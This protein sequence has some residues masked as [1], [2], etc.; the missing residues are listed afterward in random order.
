MAGDGALGVHVALLRSINVGKANRISM[1]DLRAVFED[2]GCTDVRTYIQSGN[3]VF[4]AP[5]REVQG[6]A[7]RVEKALAAAHGIEVPVILRT[8]DELRAVTA[9]NPFPRAELAARHVVFLRDAPQGPDPLA[10]LDPA[11]HAPLEMALVGRELHLM[12]PEGMARVKLTN[13]KMD[14]AFGTATTTRN[15]RTVSKVIAML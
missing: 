11:S 8:G 13:A 4:G 14:R 9:A 12:A 15:G 5:A 7:G 2:L 1:H 6:L 10:A 3:V